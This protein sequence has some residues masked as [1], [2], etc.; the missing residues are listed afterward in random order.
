MSLI[1]AIDSSPPV[2]RLEGTSDA[3]DGHQLG[4]R[5]RYLLARREN[6]ELL[7]VESSIRA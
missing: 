1:V 2:N 4:S 6:N 5:F 3:H 7:F